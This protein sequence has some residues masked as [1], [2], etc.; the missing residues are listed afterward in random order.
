MSPLYEQNVKYY[1]L[2]NINTD[3]VTIATG[4]Q[5]KLEHLLSSFYYILLYK[6]LTVYVK[7]QPDAYS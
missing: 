4:F 2:T 3:M 6:G 5:Q 7:K 1:C